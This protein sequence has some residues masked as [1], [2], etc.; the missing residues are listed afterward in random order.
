MCPTISDK[1]GEPIEAAMKALPANA[2]GGG[3]PRECV[4]NSLEMYVMN[5]ELRLCIAGID[6]NTSVDKSGCDSREAEKEKLEKLLG[7]ICSG[8]GGIVLVLVLLECLP[9][10]DSLKCEEM[11]SNIWSR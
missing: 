6:T 2:G 10:I 9:V 11:P 1:T 8:S 5:I 7:G 4:S 3:W